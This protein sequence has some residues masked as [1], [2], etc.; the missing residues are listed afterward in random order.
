M[1]DIPFYRSSFNGGEWDDSNDC[2][3]VV[4]EDRGIIVLLGQAPVPG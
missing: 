4:V 2:G 1:G 3:W